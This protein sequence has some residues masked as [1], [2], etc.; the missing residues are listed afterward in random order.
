MVT[1]KVDTPDTIL[2]CIGTKLTVKHCAEN[3]VSVFVAY[4]VR[5]RT[6]LTPVTSMML[7][8]FH[9]LQT[10]DKSGLSY[11]PQKRIIMFKR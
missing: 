1:N 3:P 11:R 5:N 7:A 6:T 9:P 2:L 4:L 8:I 10:S